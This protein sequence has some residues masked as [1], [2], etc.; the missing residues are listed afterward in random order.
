MLLATFM[1]S[2]IRCVRLI[3]TI[4]VQ[5]GSFNL[6]PCHGKWKALSSRNDEP[7]KASRPWDKAGFLWRHLHGPSMQSGDSESRQIKNIDAAIARS[8]SFLPGP[9]WFRDGRGCRSAVFGSLLLRACRVCH[10]GGRWFFSFG[11]FVCRR[12][13][14]SSW[15]AATK[16]LEHAQKRGATIYAE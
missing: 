4:T 14:T 2:N 8:C 15:I 13:F 7:E 11:M 10:L 16:S 9:G 1:L 6:Q 12:E 3:C 5:L